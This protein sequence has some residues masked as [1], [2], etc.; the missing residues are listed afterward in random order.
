MKEDNKTLANLEEQNPELTEL[1]VKG[2]GGVKAVRQNR[3]HKYQR[4]NT[5]QQAIL[6]R[7]K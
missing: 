5:R 6:R 3:P 2:K 4:V 1:I 7:V